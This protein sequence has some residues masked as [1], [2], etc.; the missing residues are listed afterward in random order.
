MI[1]SILLK[2]LLIYLFI[3]S[4]GIIIIAAF[5]GY[6]GFFSSPDKLILTGE[7]SLSP[8]R[9]QVNQESTLHISIKNQEDRIKEVS[10]SFNTTNPLVSIHYSNGTSLGKPEKIGHYYVTTYP[11]KKLLGKNE[12][13]RVTL[14]VNAG[15]L[16]GDEGSDY[17]IKVELFGDR[18]LSDQRI[19]TLE[20]NRT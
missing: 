13:W 15:L 5:A 16:A 7:T 12:G 6:L 9:I 4:I 8:T 2:K 10:F 18:E 1:M 11:V 20:V 14:I 19:F 3:G 17:S